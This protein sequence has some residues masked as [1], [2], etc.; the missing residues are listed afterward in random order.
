LAFLAAPFLA[1]AAAAVFFGVA[2]F[3]AAG[4]A[5]LAA[6]AGEALVEVL[7]AL[8]GRP[9]GLADAAAGAS[10]ALALGDA[11]LGFAAV[12]AFAFGDALVPWS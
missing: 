9:R 6:L 3:L 4:A 11:A 8:G 12:L 10:L 1:G 7:A 2:A 5:F